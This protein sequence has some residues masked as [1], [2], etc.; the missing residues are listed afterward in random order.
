MNKVVGI[1]GNFLFSDTPA[2][3]SALEARE[4]IIEQG[5]GRVSTVTQNGNLLEETFFKDDVKVSIS[6]EFLA[7]KPRI[8][9]ED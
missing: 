4:S 9:Y 7:V 2:H 1:I 3:N 6:Y 5:F 8:H